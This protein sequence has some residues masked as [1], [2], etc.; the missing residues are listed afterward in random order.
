MNLQRLSIFGT[1]NIG[2]YIYTNNKYTV[3]P[4]GLDSETKEN[5]VQY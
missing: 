1:D 2:V 5:I 4:R 3:V